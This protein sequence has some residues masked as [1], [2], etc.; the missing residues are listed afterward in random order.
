MRFIA[1]ARVCNALE[2]EGSRL[3]MTQLLADLFTEA[4]AQEA[5][6]IAYVSL[7]TLYPVYIGTQ[8]HIAEKSMLQILAQAYGHHY[9]EVH[10]AQKKYGDLGVVAYYLADMLPEN[11]APL[12]LTEV[13]T[14]LCHIHAIVGEG[15]VERKAHATAQLLMLLD[16]LS[17]KYVVRIIIGKL[18]MGFSDMT[19]LDA[20]SWS[21]TGNKSLRSPLEHAYNV[22]ADIGRIAKTLKAFGMEAI[23]NMRCVPGIP[24][25]PASA[26][27]LPNPLAIFDKLGVCVAQPKLDGFRLQVH[28]YKDAG[29]L[30]V[31]FFSRNLNDMTGMFPDL[32]AAIQQRGIQNMIIEGEAIA[33]DVD[34]GSFLPFQE[35]VKR[36]RKHGIEKVAE[37]YPLRF[38]AFDLLALDGQSWLNQPHHARRAAL[39][40][41]FPPADTQH[42]QAL[43]VIDERSIDNAQSLTVYFN[44]VLSAGLEGLVVKRP[45]A[46]YTPGKRNFNWVKLKRHEKGALIDTIDVVVLGYYAGH[47]KRALFGIGAFLVGVY[48]AANDCYETIAKIG[49]GLSDEAWVALKRRCDDLAVK[50]KPH[51]IVCAPELYPDVWIAPSLVCEVRADEVTRSPLHTAGRQESRLGYALRFPRFIAYRD[52]RSPE[53]STSIEEIDRLFKIQFR[54]IASSH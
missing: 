18:R 52:D 48:N 3:K 41:I 27:R 21:I 9:D 30:V 33:Y 35:T 24:I 45:D 16:P 15:S 4:S 32:V 6:Y 47:G 7:G 25:R 36:R 51:N 49:T 13:Y 37:A 29:A 12:S 5:A 39:A 54:M 26:E 11:R 19:L 40:S 8:F 38:F 34:T 2:Q 42:T 14:Q 10:A 28:V 46:I 53:D 43:C 50:E 44:E 17:V 20:L 31:R 23:E 22:T 1:L